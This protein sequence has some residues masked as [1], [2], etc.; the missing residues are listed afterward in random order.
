MIFKST[1]IKIIVEQENNSRSKTVTPLWKWILLFSAG[2][3]KTPVMDSECIFFIDPVLSILPRNIIYESQ[4]ITNVSDICLIFNNFCMVTQ[5]FCTSGWR[6]PFSGQR[7]SWGFLFF[8]F[9]P[10]PTIW[11][12]LCT[13]IFYSACLTD[14]CACLK[15]SHNFKRVFFIFS[16]K[17]LLSNSCCL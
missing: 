7:L 14:V 16:K 11:P 8:K 9:Q 3:R 4:K 13:Y 12:L 15:Q 17:F 2:C 1:I 10:P 5:I 6:L